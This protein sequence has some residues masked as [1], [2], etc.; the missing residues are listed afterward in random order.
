MTS[1]KNLMWVQ[2]VVWICIYGGLLS[3][4]LSIFLA[5]SEVTLARAMQAVGAVFVLIGV[6]LIYVRSR[7]KETPSSQVT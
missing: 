4:V 1:K 3:I 2:R 7:L 5:R 6:I